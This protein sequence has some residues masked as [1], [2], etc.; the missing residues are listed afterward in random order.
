MTDIRW[1]Q[2]FQNYE[3]V[4]VKL[5]HMV[6]RLHATPDDEAVHMAVVQAFEFTYE[7]GWKVLKDYLTF[8]GNPTTTA[9]DS[10]KEAFAL[11]IV[12]DGQAWIDMIQ[13]RNLTSH[14]YDEAT[15]QKL[16]T[17]VVQAYLPAFEDLLTYL[18]E[19]A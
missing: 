13:D 16:L 4:L 1:M 11:N 17:H 6:Q 18:K 19:K 7:L 5:Q 8:Q 10:I 2:R 12:K 15:A 9:R 14:V 3:K